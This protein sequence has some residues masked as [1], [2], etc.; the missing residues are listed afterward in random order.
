MPATGRYINQINDCS[1]TIPLPYYTGDR[2]LRLRRVRVSGVGH[3]ARL[4][5]QLRDRGAQH[6]LKNM[7]M[8]HLHPDGVEWFGE[9]GSVKEGILE[10]AGLLY[11]CGGGRAPRAGEMESADINIKE[12]ERKASQ[13]FFEVS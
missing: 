9:R 12:K 4:S 2:R 1:N 10:P 8:I 6:R 3:H 11:F 13:P 5:P 7:I